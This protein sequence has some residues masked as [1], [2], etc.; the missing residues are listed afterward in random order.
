MRGEAAVL[1][2]RKACPRREEIH[3]FRTR[4]T[5]QLL[6]W[7]CNVQVGKEIQGKAAP[8][9]WD[10]LWHNGLVLEGGGQSL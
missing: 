1:D 3:Q 7:L 9:N 4:D 6:M 10:R 8:R 5:Y 2:P